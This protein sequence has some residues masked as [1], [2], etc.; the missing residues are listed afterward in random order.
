M[1][2]KFEKT[3]FALS[4]AWGMAGVS[5]IRISGD[6]SKKVLRKLCNINLPKPRNAYYKKIFDLENNVIDQGVITFFESPFSYTGE[7]T[8]EISIH[9]S[10]AVIKKLLHTL[11][12]HFA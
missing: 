10:I 6:E 1:N 7:D 4:S 8:I 3:I 11:K 9:G 12:V 2:S 5:V